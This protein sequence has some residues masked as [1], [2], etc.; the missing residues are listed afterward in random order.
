M[1]LTGH[2]FL[3][4][5]IPK[6]RRVKIGDVKRSIQH[7][8]NVCYGFEDTESCR[9]AW[10]QVEEISSAYARERERELLTKAHDPCE[11]DPAAC[12]EYDV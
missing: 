6:N 4:A 5:S 7:A 11:D 2:V 8:R 9:V 1:I 12:R 10:D 3:A